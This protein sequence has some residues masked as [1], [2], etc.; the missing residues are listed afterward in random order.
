[1]S[2]REEYIIKE[3]IPIIRLPEIIYIIS[4][5]LFNLAVGGLEGEIATL[6]LRPSCHI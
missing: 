1:M 6:P 5:Y 4:I 2:V 3:I